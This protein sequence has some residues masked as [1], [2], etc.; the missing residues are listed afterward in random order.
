MQLR[1]AT[2]ACLLWED[3]FYQ[4]GQQG[5]DNI[6]TLIP[7]CQPQDVAALTVECRVVQKL[8]HVPLYMMVEMAKYPAMR[9]LLGD[10]IPQVVSRADEMAEFLALYWKDG[11]KSIAKQIKLGLGKAFG[12]FNEYQLGK[13]NRDG[14]VKMR[15]VLRMCHPHPVDT[16]QA[17]LWKKVIDGT[18][19][20]PDTWEVALSAGKDKKATWERL[21]SENHLGALALLRNLRNMRDV[22]VNPGI[23]RK[24][25]NEMRT[26]WVLPINFF[27]A[28]QYAPDYERELEAA[29]LRTLG[30]VAKL[31]GHTVLIID[32][33]GSMN[34]AVSQNVNAK[35]PAPSRFDVACMLAILAA[36]TCESVSV[37]MTCGRESGR[38]QSERVRAYHG[39]ALRNELIAARGRCGYNGIYTRQV[40]EW[41]KPQE[42][43]VDRIMVFS[44]SQDV[45]RQNPIP[46][47][48]GTNNYIIDVSSNARGINYQGR[49]TA[50]L[51]GWSEHFMSYIRALEG[52]EVV[53]QEDE[54]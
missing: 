5:A 47:P 11:K 17:A 30:S 37:Y 13:Y 28:L 34:S 44:D 46:N 54:E 2:L 9:R 36:E 16:A 49:W 50:E 10:L 32:G 38:H 12:K 24:A 43:K 8:R 1:R 23:I 42:G 26:D 19:A 7:L 15:D 21:I 3:A 4:T 48:F 51:S 35:T 18:L 29:M 27:R 20:T 40:L 22:G 39:F 31:P 33:S 45:D 41:V 52:I 6:S 53:A 14:V 25:L